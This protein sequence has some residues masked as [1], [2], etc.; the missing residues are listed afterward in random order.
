VKRDPDLWMVT[1]FGLGYLRPAPGTWGSLPSVVIAA[2]LIAAGAGPAG[3]ACVYWAVLGAITLIFT[4]ACVALGDKAEARF[5]KKDPSQVVAD[6][7]AGQAVTLLFLPPAAAATSRPGLAAC[8]LLA[9]FL[10]FRAMDIIKP[11]PARQIQSVPGGWGVVL[12]DL[13]AGVYAGLIVLVAAEWFL[14]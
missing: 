9:A 4:A 6:E 11:W 8:W 7:T 1:V 2:A 10:A 14:R 3:K 5:W 12:D 13:V